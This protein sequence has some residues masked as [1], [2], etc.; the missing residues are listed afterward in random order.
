MSTDRQYLAPEE[1]A[2]MW[3]Y[4]SQYAKSGMSARQ[5]WAHIAPTS[6]GR[7]VRDFVAAMR[8]A[9]PARVELS[10]AQRARKRGRA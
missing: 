5:W 4:G 7:V 6:Y 1:V 9:L 10:A 3:L 8:A 2:A